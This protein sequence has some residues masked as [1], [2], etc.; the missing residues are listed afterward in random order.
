MC[1]AVLDKRMLLPILV[2][3]ARIDKLIRNSPAGS[4]HH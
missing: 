3:A 4:V 2:G 1:L